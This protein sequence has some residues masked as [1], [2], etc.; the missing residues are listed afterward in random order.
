M[1]IFIIFFKNLDKPLYVALAWEVVWQWFI[2]YVP[3]QLI[4]LN[5]FSLR[6]ACEPTGYGLIS[7]QQVLL[8]E[9]KHWNVM[10]HSS[11]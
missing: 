7:K 4:E 5:T 9:K 6:T 10:I 1:S 8:S 3:E 11:I 2:F